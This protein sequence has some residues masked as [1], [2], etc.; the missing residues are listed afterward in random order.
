MLVLCPSKGWGFPWYGGN[1]SGL[2]FQIQRFWVTYD[3][4][5][6]EFSSFFSSGNPLL[7]VCEK[8][9][10]GN[11]AFDSLAGNLL[12][13]RGRGGSFVLHVSS[14]DFTMHGVPAGSVS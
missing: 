14:A 4:I 1:S 3:Q 8:S 6:A 13:R 9:L 2:N 11:L 5:H 12:E 10:A 7:T